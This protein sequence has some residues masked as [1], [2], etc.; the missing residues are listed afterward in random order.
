[1]IITEAAVIAL[2]HLGRPAKADEIH[3][4][5]LSLRL[6]TIDEVSKSDGVRVKIEMLCE[7]SKRTDKPNK[8]I[9][10][11]RVSPGTYDLLEVFKDK[12]KVSPAVLEVISRKRRLNR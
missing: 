3:K 2:Q 10:F 9:R 6:M 7:N 12:S 5:I 11:R 8:T 4:T 1:M